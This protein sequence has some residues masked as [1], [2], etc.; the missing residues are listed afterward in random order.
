MRERERAKENSSNHDETCRLVA[1][2]SSLFV[3]LTFQ[4]NF[5][6]LNNFLLAFFLLI[7]VI[8][9]CLCVEAKR[10]D[11]SALLET[12][13]RARERERKEERKPRNEHQALSNQKCNT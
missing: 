6:F 9:V 12:H 2:V 1:L 8:T 10:V 7:I 11:E 5:C 13:H 3:F 4:T